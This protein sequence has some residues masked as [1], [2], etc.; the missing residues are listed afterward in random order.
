[1]LVSTCKHTM[2]SCKSTIFQTGL[3]HEGFVESIAVI[4]KTSR[5]PSHVPA[6][7]FPLFIYTLKYLLSPFLP[8]SLSTAAFSAIISH[9]HSQYG[10]Y[11]NRDT[12]SAPNPSSTTMSA[13]ETTPSPAQMT[14]D[15][16]SEDL[17]HHPLSRQSSTYSNSSSA[18]ASSAQQAVGSSAVAAGQHIEFLLPLPSGPVPA[19]QVDPLSRDYPKPTEEVNVAE[20]LRRKPMKWSIGHYIKQTGS[21]RAA[22]TPPAEDGEWSAQELEARK[23]KLLAAK[24][25]MRRLA[26]SN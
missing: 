14:P 16:M 19:P 23:G 13:L 25:E 7:T 15:M 17:S 18:S 21:A 3:D 4:F 6:C 22:S 24:E 5:F 12:Q 26:L 1:M 9:C 20:M 10:E 2:A 8:Y 11:R